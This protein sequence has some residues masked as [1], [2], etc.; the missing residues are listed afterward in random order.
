M[1]RGF[2]VLA[3]VAY[4]V[5]VHSVINFIGAS[6]YY[7][8]FSQFVTFSTSRQ[9]TQFTQVLVIKRSSHVKSWTTSCDCFSVAILIE[10]SCF[11]KTQLLIGLNGCK[12]VKSI[13]A[14]FWCSW[15]NVWVDI[16]IMHNELYYLF[17]ELLCFW[18]NSIVNHSCLFMLDEFKN[19]GSWL[20]PR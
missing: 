18:F 1:R 6:S 16:A 8:I 10:L 11:Y 19:E 14:W 2:V 3:S 4:S 13:H 12:A 15:Y 7:G 20:S 17:I 9:Q 5:T